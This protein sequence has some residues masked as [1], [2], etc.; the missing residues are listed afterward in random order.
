MIK[1]RAVVPIN[2]EETEMKKILN[3][4]NILFIFAA[5]LLLLYVPTIGHAEEERQTLKLGQTTSLVNVREGPGETV[6]AVKQ[7]N[8]SNLQLQAGTQII[9]TEESDFNGKPWYHVIFYINGVELDGWI[10]SSYAKVS[11][12]VTATPTPTPEVTETPTPTPEPTA[13][14]TPEPTSTPKPT[15]GPKINDKSDLYKLFWKVVIAVLVLGVVI[16]VLIYAYNK[17]M[18]AKGR[19]DELNKKMKYLKSVAETPEEPGK[20]VTTAKRPQVRIVDDGSGEVTKSAEAENAPDE[21]AILRAKLDKLKQ[22]DIVEH[23]F[24]GKGEVFDNSDVKLMEVRFG[25]DVRYLNKDSLAAK[26]LLTF[27]EDENII[28][29]KKL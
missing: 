16:I 15:E 26:K 4:R 8:G 12:T 7:Y 27:E 10:T 24:F 22:H 5:L 2:K 14:P 17:F 19:N 25:M 1:G 20:A 9:I 21:R 18:G 28:T 11:G 29:R 6:Y 23:K 13:T 3:T